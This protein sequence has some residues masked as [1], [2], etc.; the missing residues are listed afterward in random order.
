LFLILK[1]CQYRWKEGSISCCPP[2]LDSNYFTAWGISITKIPSH[3]N[4]SFYFFITLYFQV[5][6]SKLKLVLEN[7][8]NVLIHAAEG[9]IKA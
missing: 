4:Y 8:L 9:K 7:R 2:D 6:E 5:L 3:S 1:K